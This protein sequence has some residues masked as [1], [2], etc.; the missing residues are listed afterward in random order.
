[1]QDILSV[2]LQE[3][4]KAN[5]VNS[6]QL[7]SKL[8]V[9]IQRIIGA[10]KSLEAL[11][12]VIATEMYTV[13]RWQLTKEGEEVLTEGSHEFRVFDLIPPEGGIE[14]SSLMEACG[15]WGK[16]GFSKAMSHGWIMITR[17]KVGT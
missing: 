17:T 7:A 15:D 3:L 6:V 9:D 2:I 4:E 13:K 14:Q 10:I 8:G 5:E 12:D 1:M 16:I 11:G